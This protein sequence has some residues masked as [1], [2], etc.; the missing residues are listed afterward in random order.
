MSINFALVPGVCVPKELNQEAVCLSP[1]SHLFASGLQLPSMCHPLAAGVVPR[2]PPA[3]L[4][5]RLG[6]SLPAQKGERRGG[7]LAVA[8]HGTEYARLASIAIGLTASSSIATSLSSNRQTNREGAWSVK[9]K[10][11]GGPKRK[12]NSLHEHNVWRA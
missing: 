12:K 3:S 8:T 5:S 10:K 6:S 11:T 9:P 7:I 1:H 2:S 4:A